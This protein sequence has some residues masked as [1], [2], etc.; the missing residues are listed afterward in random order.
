M[1]FGEILL[2]EQL[3]TWTGA[4][5]SLQT[6]INMVSQGGHTPA[7]PTRHPDQY[8]QPNTARFVRLMPDLVARTKREEFLH[9]T[10]VGSPPPSAR[11]HNQHTLSRL[12]VPGVARFRK[13]FGRLAHRHGVRTTLRELTG[14]NIK[15]VREGKR[16]FA[17]QSPNTCP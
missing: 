9:S 5:S 6:P 12:D 1:S 7:E 16:L 15:I 4:S 10:T 8:H 17:V 2:D 13:H 11:R 3:P 14:G